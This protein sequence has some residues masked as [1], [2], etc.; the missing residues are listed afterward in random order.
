[1]TF[2]SLKEPNNGIRNSD[3]FMDLS[4]ANGVSKEAYYMYL[5]EMT[6]GSINTSTLNNVIL[7]VGFRF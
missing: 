7:T 3:F 2:H 4:Y 1:M 5:P 6:T